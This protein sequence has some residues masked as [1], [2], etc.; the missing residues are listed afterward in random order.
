MSAPVLTSDNRLRAAINR[1]NRT[2]RIL[3]FES[4]DKN[5]WPA[6]YCLA[7]DSLFHLGV[8]ICRLGG[9]LVQA[10]CLLLK[11]KKRGKEIFPELNDA[12]KE[13][14]HGKQPYD[15]GLAASIL[16]QASRSPDDSSIKRL[17]GSPETFVEWQKL[18][19][20]GRM[21]IKE[22]TH[23]YH[24]VDWIGKINKL[25]K[26][27]PILQ[28][29]EFQETNFQFFKDKEKIPSFP[30]VYFSQ[31][32]D[33]WLY[34]WGF[35]RSE[36]S[37]RITF[38][39]PH[40]TLQESWEPHMGGDLA[41]HYDL[42]LRLL[43]MRREERIVYLFGNQYQHLVTLAEAIVE[44]RGDAAAKA[45]KKLLE[46]LGRDERL[47]R[48]PVDKITLLLAN[49]GPS[50]VL[51]C[52][53]EEE[54][55]L[56]D[57]YLKVLEHN[58]HGRAKEGLRTLKTELA[59][60]EH[61]ISQCLDLDTDYKA[62]I[63]SPIELELRCWVVMRASGLQADS[64]HPYV[65]S[66]D[67]RLNMCRRWLGQF[68]DKKLDVASVATKTIKM[69]ERTFRFLCCFYEGL[70]AYH[71][72]ACLNPSDIE[73]HEQEMLQAAARA[74]KELEAPPGPLID[75]LSA[76]VNA[77][78]QQY[79][80][81]LLGRKEICQPAAF[82]R[83]VTEDWKKLFN[84][85]KHDLKHEVRRDEVRHFLTDTI[86]LFELFRHGTE[87]ETANDTLPL[88]PVYPHVISFRE[89]HRKRD[90]LIIHHHEIYSSARPA[91][92]SAE[93]RHGIGVL[94]SHDYVPHE[95]YY[96]IPMFNRA[97]RDW[98][99]DPFLIRCSEFD[100][101][102]PPYHDQEDLTSYAG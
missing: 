25:T 57:T 88:A 53:L 24:Q 69:I 80:V 102:V 63:R 4:L 86:R 87:R 47:P 71:D 30:L 23:K 20:Y 82:S 66:V 60:K 3:L 51:H 92:D 79:I 65:E 37:T 38:I 12:M 2:L 67:M 96:C 85:I 27:L 18:L 7:N 70:A 8:N 98:W 97:T 84:R 101:Y 13:L 31:A 74:H 100:S 33:V 19:D 15:E 76:L 62:I 75:R 9:L 16:Y 64:P 45:R 61:I 5:E 78:N 46:E 36:Q 48:N 77:P 50:G 94:S 91:R 1:I 83:I 81:A 72:S 68:E 56:C 28:L 21:G 52:A 11:K 41:G 6:E 10:Y 40:G 44:A 55:S 35:H 42:S 54:Y 89:V 93:Q 49:H 95:E 17:V 90:G 29:C 99:L 34:V 22:Y 58:G 32:E 39:Y 43:G 26:A 59:R 73:A 14:W